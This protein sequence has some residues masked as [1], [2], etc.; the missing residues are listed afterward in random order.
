MS[1]VVFS[2]AGCGYVQ[3]KKVLGVKSFVE[4]AAAHIKEKIIQFLSCSHVGGE[5]G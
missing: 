4:L 2:L 1:L 5:S 3:K